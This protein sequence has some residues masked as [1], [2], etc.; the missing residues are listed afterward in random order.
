[1]RSKITSHSLS[2]ETVVD[3]VHGYISVPDLRLE[4][5]PSSLSPFKAP[6][7][8]RRPLRPIICASLPL[9]FH[10]YYGKAIYTRVQ[11]ISSQSDKMQQEESKRSEG[12]LIRNSSANKSVFDSEAID[13][14]P[15]PARKYIAS[16]LRFRIV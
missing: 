10:V 7:A 5:S 9:P 12:K 16:E 1:M 11:N 13:S 14:E 6:S 15:K 4:E 2:P 3:P 8:L